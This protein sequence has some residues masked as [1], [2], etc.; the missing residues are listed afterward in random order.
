[1]TLTIDAARTYA[2]AQ[3]RSWGYSDIV[4]SGAG[5][6]LDDCEAYDIVI[7]G[8]KAGNDDITSGV[9]TVWV[10]YPPGTAPY[11]DGEW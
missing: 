9:M 4:I 10:Q 3:L 1:M 5:A 11:I 6:N 8:R 2:V 7:A